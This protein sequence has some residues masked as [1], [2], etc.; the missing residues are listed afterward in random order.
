MAIDG[1][2]GF[3]S[4]VRRDDGS[5][6]LELLI[7]DRPPDAGDSTWGINGQATMTVLDPTWEPEI[8]MKIWGGANM[9]E[10]VDGPDDGHRPVYRREGYTKLREA[11][12]YP[13]GRFVNGPRPTEHDSRVG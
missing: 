8:G 9:V 13:R 5:P 6:A 4:K 1:V 12:D 7:V 10:I 3:V 2:I 11:R